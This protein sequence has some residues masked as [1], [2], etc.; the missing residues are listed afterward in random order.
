MAD[1]PEEFAFDGKDGAPVTQAD[2]D[3][4]IATI[5]LGEEVEA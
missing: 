3:Q 1:I 5:Q 2:I 4:T